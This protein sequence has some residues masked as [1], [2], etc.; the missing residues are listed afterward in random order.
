[1]KNLVI[2][3]KMQLKEQLNFKRLSIKDAKKFHILV[4]ILAAVLK[5][6]LVTAL[7]AAFLIAA[8]IIG[9]FSLGDL[10]VPT[11]VISIVFSVMLIAGTFSCVIGLTKSIYYARDNAVLLTLPCLPIQ[12]YLS[13]LIVF[14]VFELKRNLSFTVPLFIAYYAVYGYAAWTYFWMLL[15]M[16][17]ISL[18]TVSIG[19]LLSIP[20]MW[21]SAFFRR[22][23]SL[24]IAG[25][26]VLSAIAICA[27]FFAISLI[28][29]DIDL[30]ATWTTTYWK[31]QDALEWYSVYLSPLYNVALMMLGETENLVT[32]FPF[33][34]TV[35]RF[36]VIF[37][38]TAVLMGLGLCI[39]QP[40]FYKMASTPFEYLKRKVP[41]KKNRRLTRRF[42]AFYNEFLMAIKSPNRMIQNI[43]IFIS[44]P[45]LIYLLNKI[46]IVMKTRE[47]GD[48]MVVAFN[49]I[50]ILLIILNSNTSF[51]SIFSRDG[52]TIYLLKT[53]PAKYMLLILAKLLPNSAFV[54]GSVLATLGI[55]LGTIKSLSAL[56]TLL[57]VAAIS[58]T[59]LAHMCYCAELDLMNPQTELYA[60]VGNSESNP[61]ETKATISAFLI[62][63]C[64][65]GVIFLVLTDP[66][67]SNVYAK[68]L[69]VAAAALI[70]RV[71]LLFS[72]VKVYYKEK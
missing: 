7:C 20:A 38:I 57:L 59:Y 36:L 51:A 29:D 17:L 32:Y 4:S 44:V 8:Q 27:V 14:F 71:R 12:V 30:L 41:P 15:C 54:A 2:L 45:M 53:H 3:V 37:G 22:Y 64:V 52:R 10:P 61:N 46:F 9:L 72:N 5:F 11:T 24:Q 19:A 23:R 69:L 65:G 13:K 68:Y 18:F 63:F 48:H 21:I 58:F 43:G 70:W 1:M 56:D 67:S 31:I 40:L 62:S 49:V 47:L 60:T 34:N 39:V 35:L 50:I 55:M 25:I 42:S 33:W 6:A 28:P 16:V 66:T 26:T